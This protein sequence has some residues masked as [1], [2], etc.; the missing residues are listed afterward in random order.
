LFIG[1]VQNKEIP[2]LRPQQIVEFRDAFNIF[3]KNGDGRMT[4]KAL[5]KIMQA[6]WHYPATELEPMVADVGTEGTETVEFAEFLE[7]MAKQL[8]KVRIEEDVKA[9]RCLR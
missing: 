4:V 7:M 5:G 1:K 9:A 8:E 3:D 6:P 2:A